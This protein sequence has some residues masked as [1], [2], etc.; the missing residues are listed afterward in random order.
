PI[1]AEVRVGEMRPPQRLAPWSYA[2]AVDVVPE[3]EVIA[4]SRLVLL[5]DPAG[6]Q[7]WRG[8]LRLVGYASADLDPEIGR[9]PLLPGV[10]WSWLLDALATSGAE[11]AAAG[12]TVT[13]TAS[14]RFGEVIRA[15]TA[16]ATC[17]LE[18]RASWTPVG[19]GLGAHLR[20][21]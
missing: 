21:W 8:T 15:G 19:P 6:H 1:R 12:G 9:D 13:A 10:G 16:A 20:G 7:A 5:Y 2:L 14:T 17:T 3:Q 18:L 11:H 4:S